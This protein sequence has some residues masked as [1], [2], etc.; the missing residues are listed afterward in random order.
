MAKPPSPR[1]EDRVISNR[2]EVKIKLFNIR[3]QR[4]KLQKYRWKREVGHTIVPW[5]KDDLWD[6]AG[7][8]GGESE[9]PQYKTEPSLPVISNCKL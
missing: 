4:K 3:F 2:E 1:K 6:S 9:A 5:M 8:V 7:R